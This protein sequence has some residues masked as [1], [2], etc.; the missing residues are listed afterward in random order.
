MSELCPSDPLAGGTMGE[1]L[2]TSGP[3]FVFAAGWP[4]R[5]ETPGG[6]GSLSASSTAVTIGWGEPSVA[7]LSMGS[8]NHQEACVSHSEARRPAPE[9]SSTFRSCRKG[10]AWWPALLL[11]PIAGCIL[12]V[13]FWTPPAGA[14]VL[15]R[16]AE[17][18][19]WGSVSAI[20][21]A[22]LA[23]PACLFLISRFQP[24]SSRAPRAD[25]LPSVALVISAYNEQDTIGE[26]IENCLALDYPSDRY[27][28]LVASDG[29]TDRTAEIAREYAPRGVRLI[30]HPTRRGKSSMLNA[31]VSEL[32]AKA[33]VFT[34][35]NTF[36]AR[37]ALRML[38]RNFSDP[39]VGC[40]VGKMTYLVPVDWDGVSPK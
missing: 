29:S 40:V 4:T 3:P 35:A 17:F 10:T 33:I 21:Y 18:I 16:V 5:R 31:V 22:Y 14:A 38:L 27:T 20:L 32:D 26:R 34:D 6:S 37:D 28:I 2:P 1:N 9:T 23:Y 11:A 8:R 25:Y 19:L 15:P 13:A 36:F 12:L 24:P 39:D 30:H 7:P